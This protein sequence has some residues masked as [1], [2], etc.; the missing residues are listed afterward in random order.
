MRVIFRL[1]EGFGMF[2]EPLA[3]V[4]WFTPL[5]S[6][7]PDIEMHQISHSTRMH[8]RRA[9]IIPISLIERTVHLIPKFGR[10]VC[11]DWTADNVL[12]KCDR[13][14]VNPYYRHIDFVL[15]RYLA[16]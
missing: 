4:Q 6:I 8:S 1:P 3:Y 12:E 5:G 16:S 2:S 14:F 10:E 7:A 13:F 15:F 11:L 9:S